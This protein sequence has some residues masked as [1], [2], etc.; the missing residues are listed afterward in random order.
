MLEGENTAAVFD[1]STIYGEGRAHKLVAYVQLLITK[2]MA[3]FIKIGRME[4]GAFSES[5]L[6]AE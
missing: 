3:V 5:Y 4:N 6:L 2:I 1:F